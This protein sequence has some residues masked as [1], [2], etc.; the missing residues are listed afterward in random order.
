MYVP[1][2]NLHAYVTYSELLGECVTTNSRES[3]SVSDA[4][5]GP[6][7]RTETKFASSSPSNLP[8]EM[9]LAA[10]ASA[11]R[12]VVLLL[13][14]PITLS[15]TLVPSGATDGGSGIAAGSNSPAGVDPVFSNPVFSN[16]PSATPSSSSSSSIATRTRRASS[17]STPLTVVALPAG[18]HRNISWQMTRDSASARSPAA[19]NA[20][21]SGSASPNDASPDEWGLTRWRAVAPEASTESSEP[22]SPPSTPSPYV[23]LPR[24]S[25]R[26]TPGGSGLSA[27]SR[28]V[29]RMGMGSA[30]TAASASEDAP[31]VPTDI[32]RR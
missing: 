2:G 6:P 28:L 20:A 24:A 30:D 5:C 22:R 9:L 16:V 29:P 14:L 8:V 15:A 19:R 21:N 17:T 32:R 18:L 31:T 3:S 7:N 11:A 26:S 1:R 27:I 13:G 10:A 25:H 12:A 4:D 23:A